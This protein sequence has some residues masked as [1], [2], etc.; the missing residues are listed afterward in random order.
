MQREDVFAE[1]AIERIFEGDIV[2]NVRRNGEIEHIR[3]RGFHYED[4]DV[5]L[6][7]GI[8]IIEESRTAPDTRGVY[9]AVIMVRGHRRR[10][11]QYGFFPRRLS[12]DEVLQTIVEAY[13]HRAIVT[14]GNQELYKGEG[15]GLN[16]YMQ[17]D[18][19]GRVTDAW[20]RRARYSRTQRAIWIY[21]RTGK[22]SKLLCH[23]CLQPK[24][25]CCV[26]HGHL[27]PRR[28]FYSRIKYH[29][30]RVWFGLLEIIELRKSRMN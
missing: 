6:A 23:I 15:C 7:R 24:V 19:A 4:A 12:R 18:D 25:L 29:A 9:K 21:A 10:A 27:P 26:R 17:L 30:R 20:P 28:K 5:M 11:A 14:A 2:P 16:I 3:I 22:R 8:E 13:E 1:G